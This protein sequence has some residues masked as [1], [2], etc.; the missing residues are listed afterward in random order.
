MF[1]IDKS[2]VEYIDSNKSIVVIKQWKQEEKVKKTEAKEKP[3]AVEE[4]AGNLTLPAENPEEIIRNAKLDAE[5]IVQQAINKVADIKAEAWREGYAKGAEESRAEYEALCRE[6][7]EKFQAAMNGLEELH[8]EIMAELEEDI[9]QLSLDIAEKIVNIQLERDDILFV[10]LVK[11]AVQKLNPK[12]KF[13]LRVNQREYDKYFANG[14]EWLEIELESAPLSVV[15]DP[16]IA[17]GGCVLESD[18]G[19][20]KAGMD[21]QLKNIA[22]SL[23][24]ADRQYDEAL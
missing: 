7:R 8:G 20:I 23:N 13:I 1:K 15:R 11:N 14:S 17:P 12:E 9:L 4:A 16:T 19:I 24:L 22:A 21:V 5:M 6:N 2:S 18:E 10:G 3:P